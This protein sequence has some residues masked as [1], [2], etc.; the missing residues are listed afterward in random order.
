M[1][2]CQ[3]IN[4]IIKYILRHHKSIKDKR[5]GG[6]VT[7]TKMLRKPDGTRIAFEEIRNWRIFDWQAQ[8]ENS[9]CIN[10][11]TT[12][13]TFRGNTE[14]QQTA[15]TFL[16]DLVIINVYDHA[17]EFFSQSS[18]DFVYTLNTPESHVQHLYEWTHGKTGDLRARWM[19]DDENI[20]KI[21]DTLSIGRQLNLV[22]TAR[23]V[24]MDFEDF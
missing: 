17:A 11:I 23:E 8:S 15:R 12:G 2:V 5:P 20:E 19:T 6:G 1:K 24:D 16:S 18:I 13:Y 21:L 4:D 14:I 10:T 3:S 22:E 9:L 7:A